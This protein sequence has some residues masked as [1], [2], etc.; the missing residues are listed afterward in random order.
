MKLQE[1]ISRKEENK[2]DGVSDDLA[3]F[4][5]FFPRTTNLQ[6]LKLKE[7]LIWKASL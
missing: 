5:G 7:N 4:H 6:T 3:L 2:D 1:S